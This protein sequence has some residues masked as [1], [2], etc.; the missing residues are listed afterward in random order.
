MGPQRVELSRASSLFELYPVFGGGPKRRPCFIHCW[1]SG[2]GHHTSCGVEHRSEEGAGPWRA[3]LML[4]LGGRVWAKSTVSASV[5]LR[6]APM[7]FS[8][9]VRGWTPRD[10]R[11][12]VL[13]HALWT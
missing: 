10:R 11:G 12:S 4:A 9:I 2:V 3:R 5:P 13:F 1:L 7:Y 6:I 8:T